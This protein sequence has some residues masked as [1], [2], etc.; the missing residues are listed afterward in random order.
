MLMKIAYNGS[1]YIIAI[2]LLYCL[3]YFRVIPRL[4]N[5]YR[6]ATYAGREYDRKIKDIQEEIKGIQEK[7]KDL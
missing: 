3:F 2:V 5:H 6:K 1:V 7:G 4:I